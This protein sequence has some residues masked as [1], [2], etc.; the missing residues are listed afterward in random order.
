MRKGPRKSLNAIFRFSPLSWKT[1]E[2]RFS[3]I[4]A[5]GSNARCAQVQSPTGEND[6]DRQDDEAAGEEADFKGRPG[7]LMLAERRH[8]K[9]L[10]RTLPISPLEIIC[11]C[12]FCFMYQFVYVFRREKVRR[13][14]ALDSPFCTSI[15]RQ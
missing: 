14:H 2:S 15:D 11:H 6:R 12:G 8:A 5:A 9:T 3:I 4:I 10:H 7:T 13:L 1:A